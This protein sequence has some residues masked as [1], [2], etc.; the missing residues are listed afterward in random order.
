MRNF[1]LPDIVKRLLFSM[2]L[3]FARFNHVP[4]LL[5]YVIE[6]A[7]ADDDVWQTVPGAITGTTHTVGHLK[8]GKKYKFRIRAEN[9]YGL[10]DPVE[11]D[12]P[13]LAKNPY[14]ER[15]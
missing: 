14:G 2:V 9:M 12:K 13:V 4:F 3:T 5:G 15:G 8:N 11:L 6:R 7:D 10:S 1:S